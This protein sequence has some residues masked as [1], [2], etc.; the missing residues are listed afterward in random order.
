MHARHTAADLLIQRRSAVHGCSRTFLVQIPKAGG[1]VRDEVPA[2][3][4]AL[5]G[6]LDRVLRLHAGVAF[7]LSPKDVGKLSH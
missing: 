3:E 6:E 5:K 7:D 1:L 4:F 2:A